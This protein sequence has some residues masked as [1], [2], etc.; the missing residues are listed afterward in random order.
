MFRQLPLQLPQDRSCLATA[1]LFSSTG[2]PIETPRWQSPC[3]QN[4]I[5]VPHPEPFQLGHHL[6]TLISARFHYLCIVR[7]ESPAQ[8]SQAEHQ[9]LYVIPYS[10]LYFQHSDD[11]NPSDAHMEFLCRNTGV[12]N[13]IQALRNL[14]REVLATLQNAH[15]E[16]PISPQNALTM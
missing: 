8:T 13:I 9:F 5:N 3:S 6:H 16:W 1:P 12:A 4:P 11:H 2:P 15:Q 7:N 14:T 10:G